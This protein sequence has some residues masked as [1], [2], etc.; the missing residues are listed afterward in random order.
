MADITITLP[1]PIA[2]WID[3]QVRQHGYSSHGDYLADL[4]MQERV[5][6][7]EELSLDEVRDVVRVSRASGL[8]T[9]SVD[10]LFAE[11]EGRAGTRAAKLG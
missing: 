5:R 4:V 2:A 11:A 8:G 3:K 1:D 9:S 7:G 10:D 6:L